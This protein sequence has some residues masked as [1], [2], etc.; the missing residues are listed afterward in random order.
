MNRN[1]PDKKSYKSEYK[2]I[3]P[4]K[5]TGK[6]PIIMRS[7]WERQFAKWLDRNPN[8]EWWQSET[9]VVPYIS[10][11]DL[12]QHSYYIDFTV[13]FTN[14]KI[15]LFEIKPEK[16]TKA[17]K[18]RERKTKRFL[19]EVKTYGVN[20]SKWEAAR[21]FAEAKGVSFQILTENELRK[22]GIKIV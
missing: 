22:L 21:A 15:V 9:T 6:K 13:K 18:K 1:N 17:P 19:Q 8:V 16:Q 11:I 5:Y 20:I 10:K 4:K 3:H 7:T 12:R 14:G 2:P